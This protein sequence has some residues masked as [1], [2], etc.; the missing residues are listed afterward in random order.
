MKTPSDKFS[1]R[2]SIKNRQ[3]CDVSDLLDDL[4]DARGQSTVQKLLIA[5]AIIISLLAL[6][7]IAALVCYGRCRL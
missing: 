6:C 7:C 2:P 1:P 4:S 3:G 5:L